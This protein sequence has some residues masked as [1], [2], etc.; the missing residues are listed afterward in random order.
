MRFRF[1]PGLAAHIFDPGSP[2]S[3][4]ALV[5]PLRDALLTAN[6]ATS[7]SVNTTVLSGRRYVC[8]S[9]VLA[10]YAMTHFVPVVTTQD[11][12]KGCVLL[13]KACTEHINTDAN[14]SIPES[15]LLTTPHPLA[16]RSHSTSL[17][18]HTV[19]A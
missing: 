19:F 1:G 4:L 11:Y 17:V 8:T 18:L 15:S 6:E 3:L 10:T 7:V 5:S 12:H 9:L 13:T 14:L 2:P 16:H